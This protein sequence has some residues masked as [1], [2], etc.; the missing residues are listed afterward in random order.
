MEQYNAQGSTVDRVYAALFQRIVNAEY[1]EGAWLREDMVAHEFGV[2]RSPVRSAFRL[3][4]KDSMLELVPKRGARVRPFT[5]DDIEE[6]YEI[7][8]ALESLAVSLGIHNLSI[9]RLFALKTRMLAL[10]DLDD[11]KEMLRMDGEFHAYLIESSGRR[12]LVAIINEL[13]RLIHTLRERGMEKRSTRRATIEEHCAIL[14]AL[15]A[16][17]LNRAVQQLIDHIDKSK[18][19]LLTEISQQQLGMQDDSG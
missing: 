12:R 4:H 6:I 17:D 9:H 14:D 3:L 8:K 7:R 18:A 1:S 15:T 16:R 19:R 10:S 11:S 13:Y 2:S 5:A